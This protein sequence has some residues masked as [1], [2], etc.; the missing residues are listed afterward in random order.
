[1]K[2]NTLDRFA[3]E[4][5]LCFTSHVYVLVFPKLRDEISET[6]GIIPEGNVIGGDAGYNLN[7]SKRIPD[8]AL[9]N[10][11]TSHEKDCLRKYLLIYGYGRWKIIK[12]NSGGVLSDKPELE[13]KIFSNAFMKTII[14]FL[15]QEKGELRKFLISLIDER[16]DEQF[17]LPKKDDWGTLIKQRSP[18]WGKRIQLIFRV[19]LIVEKFK[20]ERKRNK[21]LRKKADEIAK[22]NEIEAEAVRSEINKTYDYWDNL[23][24]FLPN[25]AFYGQRPSIWWTKTHDIDL[26]RGTYKY[27]YA[28]YNMMRSDPKLSFS[29]LEKDSNFQEFPNAD[30]ITR[31]LKKLIQIIIKS[32]NNGVISFDDKKNVKEPTGFTLEDKNKILGFLIDYGVPLNSEGKSDWAGLKDQLIK[33][34]SIDASKSSQAIERLVQRLRMISQLVIQLNDNNEASVD[35][36]ILDQMDPDD[37]GFNISFDDAEK[38]NRN[39]NI[40]HFLRKHM[41][42]HGGKLFNNGLGHLIDTTNKNIEGNANN[43]P[44]NWDCSVHDISLLRAVDINGLSILNILSGNRDY[45][46][47]D[48]NISPDD[49]LNRLSY[50]CEFFREFSAGG[51]TKKKKEKDHTHHVNTVSEFMPKKKANKLV[52]NKDE[53]GN[54]I[55]P[56]IINSSLQILNLGVI[57]SQ[58]PNYHTEK[59]LFPIG[60]KSVREHSSMLKLGE[61]ALYTCEILDG[62]SKPSYKLTPHEDPE[63]P[64]IRESSTGCWVSL[65]INC[66]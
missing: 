47:G 64:I 7:K 65:F 34:L 66:I 32:E 6:C 37:D 10:K 1:L 19:C 8:M 54:I 11:W 59:N 20:Q 50:L 14:E 44:N 25:Q 39:M 38:L 58:R 22:D 24:N 61:R 60:F 4:C 42:S 56:I 5:E 29:K 13:L 55:Y 23:L 31:R 2:L 49:A 43:L 57:E 12:Q 45:N 28:N 27:G 62:G 30:T 3:F 63:N 33:S 53:E 15:P 9:A 18:A 41:L 51:K 16:L 40:L 35:E 36:N 21:E 46:F 48:V 17:I 52:I 26:L